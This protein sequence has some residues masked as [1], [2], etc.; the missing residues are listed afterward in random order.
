M[1]VKQ[2]S[3]TI[4]S[5]TSNTRVYLPGKGLVLQEPSVVALRRTGELES[6][7]EQ[8]RKM[9]GKAPEAIR[10]I[11]PIQ[12]G[13]IH[14]FEAA[15]VMLEHFINRAKPSHLLSMKPRFTMCIPLGLTPVERQAYHDVAIQAGAKHVRLVEGALSAAA[16]AGLPVNEPTGSM[17]VH[18]GGGRTDIAVLS[19]GGIV[20][21]TSLRIGGDDMDQCIADYLKLAYNIAVGENTAEHVK[22]RATNT[23]KDMSSNINGRDLASGLPKSITVSHGEVIQALQPVVDR[24]VNG[25]KSVLEKSPPEL[26]AD[27]YRRG[28]VLTGG[29]ALMNNVRLALER[30]TK[31]RVE[32]AANPLDCA[33]IGAGEMVARDRQTKRHQFIFL[34]RQFSF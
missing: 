28:I 10:V 27:I 24:L 1:A 30:E 15:R 18:I 33:I 14:D 9:I 19:L 21:G 11:R 26:S 12:R 5:G 13:V 29:G 4:D 8:A 17:V 22:M 3:L 16:G 25:V 31:L 34:K 6:A 32:V 2:A 20:T 23:D 7:G